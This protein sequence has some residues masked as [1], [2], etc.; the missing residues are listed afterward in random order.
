MFVQMTEEQYRS[1]DIDALETRQAELVSLADSD[2]DAVEYKAE[3]ERCMAEIAHRNQAIELRKASLSKL[4]A[5]AGKT[6]ERSGKREVVEDADPYDTPEYRTAFMEFVCRRTPM[7]DKF[8]TGIYAQRKDALTTTAD[9]PVMIPTTMM[10]K[11]I[12][13]LDEYG[14]IYARVAKTNIKGGVEYP[15]LDLKPVATWVG[16]T[17]VSEWQ[18]F[19]AEDKISFGYFE[20]ECRIAQTM[21][22]SIVTYDEFQRRFVPLATKAM[23]KKIEAGII[24]GTGSGQMLGITVDERITNVVN[25]GDT[26]MADWKQWRKKVKASIPRLYRNGTF[27][28]AQGTWDAYIE[29]LA[30]D[31]NA[32][33]SIGYNPVTGNEELRLMGFPVLLVDDSVLPDYDSASDGDVFAIYGKLE[34]YCINTNQQLQVVQYLDW[35]VRQHKTV[36]Y[37]VLDGKVLDPYGFMLI[38]KGDVESE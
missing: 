15:I 14:E 32:P 19:T 13:E 25:M 7:P 29:T 36:A 11:I 33:V 17:E 2:V 22:A 35:D 28:M 10:N 20:L 3:C 9:V 18:K 37:M 16:E 27:I 34:D 38:Q 26:D 31:V 30:D 24:A 1:L 23:I 12:E 6:I 4:E 5:G 8:T 21:L